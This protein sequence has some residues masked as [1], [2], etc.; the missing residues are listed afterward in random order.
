MDQG[1][2]VTYAPNARNLRTRQLP[3]QY[4][5]GQI[6]IRTNMPTIY[7]PDN[8]RT[9]MPATRIDKTPCQYAYGINPITTVPLRLQPEQP[10]VLICIRYINQ[11]IV[12]IRLLSRPYRL[13]DRR[14]LYLTTITT[15]AGTVL[16]PEQTFAAFTCR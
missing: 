3:Y 1:Y 13:T 4:A 11:P 5:Y 12:L 2:I 9:D 6:R 14:A 7:K 15:A 8:R 10:I 16:P